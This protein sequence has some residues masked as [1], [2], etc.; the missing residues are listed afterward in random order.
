MS[1]WTEYHPGLDWPEGDNV[2]WQNLCGGEW[3]DIKESDPKDWWEYGHRIRYRKREPEIPIITFKNYC[4]V[5]SGDRPWPEWV[6]LAAPIATYHRNMRYMAM[7]EDGV[8]YVFE[9][10]PSLQS[11]YWGVVEETECERIATIPKEA[12]PADWEDAIVELV[13]EGEEV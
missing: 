1:E 12:M 10:M 8:A 7:D 6:R 3:H 2:K 9:E 5:Y 13:H 4:Y 11:R